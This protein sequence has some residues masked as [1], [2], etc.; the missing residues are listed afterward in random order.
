MQLISNKKN[1]Q[2]GSNICYLIK[3]Y[4]VSFITGDM[5]LSPIL[6]TQ[7]EMKKIDDLINPI[8]YFY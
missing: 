1:G 8:N 5:S 3:Y 7:W 4:Y 2:K 6:D